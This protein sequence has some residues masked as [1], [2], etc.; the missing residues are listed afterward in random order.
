M[1]TLLV[2]FDLP[3]VNGFPHVV[4]SYKQVGIEQFFPQRPVEPL[5]VG[6]LVGL[7]RLDV[8]DGHAVE[9]GPLH[10]GVS[11]ELR[12]VV[13]AHGRR[14]VVA[15]QRIRKSDRLRAKLGDRGFPITARFRLNV[16]KRA[17]CVSP[18]R[19]D[20]SASNVVPEGA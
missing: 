2:V 17:N 8:L 10:E 3:P 18:V 13:G 12:P 5:D 7:A 14:R 9:L 6:I 4:D 15:G 1:R 20:D 16:W 11:K 19:G